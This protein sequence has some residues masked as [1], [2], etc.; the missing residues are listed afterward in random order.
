MHA[1]D[2]DKT[3]D[4]NYYIQNRFKSVVKEIRKQKKSSGTKRIKLLHDNARLHTHSD[5]ISYLTKESIIIMPH[6][7]YSPDLVSYHY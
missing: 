7:P 6:A 2:K 4:H 3:V 5:I 1:V